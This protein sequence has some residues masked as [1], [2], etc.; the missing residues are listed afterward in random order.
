[1]KEKEVSSGLRIFTLPKFHF[2]FT[3]PVLFILT[4][5][6]WFV[7]AIFLCLKEK[8]CYYCL[9]TCLLKAC[10]TSFSR[11]GGGELS[12]RI[13]KSVNFCHTFQSSFNYNQCLVYFTLFIILLESTTS[14]MT[15]RSSTYSSSRHVINTIT[16]DAFQLEEAINNTHV[17]L[18]PKLE[19][20]TVIPGKNSI[21]IEVYNLPR[22]KLLP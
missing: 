14:K 1:M 19:Q 12:T 2:S 17:L 7:G 4:F 21:L 15:P 20:K 22:I 13:T 6:V 16:V 10:W 9:C 8:M 3:F 5:L 18:T 11:G